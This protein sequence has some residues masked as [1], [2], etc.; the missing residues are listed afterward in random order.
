MSATKTFSR[1]SLASLKR[2]SGIHFR[3]GSHTQYVSY[4]LSGTIEQVDRA[5]S[6]VFAIAQK[7][8]GK[9]YFARLGYKIFPFQIGVHGIGAWADFA[10][11][12]HRRVILVECLSDWFVDESLER[13]L[14]LARHAELWFITQ[15]G[16]MRELKKRGYL[17]SLFR[18]P[19][20]TETNLRFWLCRPKGS[21]AVS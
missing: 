11:T 6:G 8:Y 7:E 20:Y 3:D 19:E 10:A 12:R 17:T 15:P 9:E 21:K 4:Y 5:H 13:K 14:E 2:R 18:C 16:G 1:V